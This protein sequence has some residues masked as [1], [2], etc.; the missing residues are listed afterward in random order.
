M[1]VGDPPMESL[2]RVLDLGQR[3][4]S[5]VVDGDMIEIPMQPDYVPED[6][7]Y[8]GGTDTEDFTSA[9]SGGESEEGNDMYSVSSEDELILMINGDDGEVGETDPIDMGSEPGSRDERLAKEIDPW[10]AHL[11]RRQTKRINQLLNHSKVVAHS[12]H[13]LRQSNVKTNHHFGVKDDR[14]VYARNRRM[15]P[16]YH[17]L[18]NAEF[19]RMLKASIISPAPCSWSFPVVIT[20]RKDGKPRFCVHY[21]A[22]NAKMKADFWPIPMIEEIFDE[23]GGAEYFSILELF[24]GYWQI[25]ICQCCREKPT[26]LTRYVTYGFLFMPFLLMNVLSTFQWMMDELLKGLDFVRVYLDD[27]ARNG[28]PASGH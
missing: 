24:T 14:P 6:P 22:L 28:A 15:A 9:T 8:N 12:L 16:A 10:L 17:K 13:Y 2:E 19:E 23:L 27:V 11:S 18:V 20:A 4:A 7:G 3:V 26:F 25:L 21:R 1:I 5:F